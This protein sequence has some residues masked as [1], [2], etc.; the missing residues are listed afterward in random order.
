MSK[1]KKPKPDNKSDWAFTPKLG[2]EIEPKLTES[3]VENVLTRS[4]PAVSI[5]QFDRLPDVSFHRIAWGGTIRKKIA[6]KCAMT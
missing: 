4:P 6:T 5:Q 1:K 2:Y 3:E